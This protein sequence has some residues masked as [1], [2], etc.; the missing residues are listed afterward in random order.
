MESRSRLLRRALFAAIGVAVLALSASAC[1]PAGARARPAYAAQS[2]DA[3]HVVALVNN[4]RAA[5][6]LGPLAEAGDAT[7]KAQQQANQMAG[8]GSI[9]HSN[10][11][12]G[13]QPGW[14]AV[15]ENV[16]A[17]GNV[18]G[19]EG[20]FQASAPH[21]ANL[22]SGSFDQVGVGVAYG[23][24]GRVYVAEEFVGR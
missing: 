8:A 11:A 13:I 18:D 1:A 15:G 19:V 9:W 7:S 12:S 22:L 2:P 3:A 6:G 16:G 14:Y 5:N 17:G 24:D 21:R 4:Y 10:L 23:G 20:A